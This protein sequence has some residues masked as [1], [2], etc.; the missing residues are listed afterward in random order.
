MNLLKLTTTLALLTVLAAPGAGAATVE[1]QRFDDT[2]PLGNSELRLNGVGL[3][4]VFIIKGYAAGLYLGEKA[5][6]WQQVSA[7]AGPKRVQLRMLR[8]AGPDDFNKALVAGIRK[9]ASEGELAALS[10]RIAQLE[11]TISTLGSTAKGD[12]I[13]L[14]YVPQRGTTLSV[15]GQQK[16]GEI[17]GA[18]FYNAVLGI[19]VGDH[20]IDARLKKGLLGQ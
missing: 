16:G 19:F 4:A 8:H 2:A 13:N 17:V 18:D 1:G 10:E 15:N 7:L 6:T 14:D 5:S 12:V 9:N 3:R 20:P 11:R